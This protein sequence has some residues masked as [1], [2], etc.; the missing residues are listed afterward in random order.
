VEAVTAGVAMVVAARAE[1][2]TGAEAG[3]AGAAWVEVVAEAVD[4]AVDGVVVE[5][6]VDEEAGKVAVVDI[7]ACTLKVQGGPLSNN[8]NALYV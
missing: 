6:M 8:C 5:V 1:A 4:G 7:K 2:A 3:G